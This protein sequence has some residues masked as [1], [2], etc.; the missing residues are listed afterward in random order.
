MKLRSL[1]LISVCGIL[2]FPLLNCATK[3]DAEEKYFLITTNLKIP[4]WQNAGAGF[5]QAGQVLGVPTVFSGPDTYDPQAQRQAF[6]QAIQSKAT[7]ILVSVADPSIMKEEIDRAIEQ[8]VPVLTLD[9]DAP[10][11]K[12][13]FFVGTNNYQGGF[14]G[15]KRLA[16]DLKNKGNVAIFS[17]VAQANLEER[18]RGY[19]DALVSSPGIKIVQIV[20]IHGDPLSR[21]RYNHADP[22]QR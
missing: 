3:H 16:L 17:I 10:A 1:L 12:R 22:W 18:L 2:L 15:G 8:G 11:S 7:G 13:L 9:S 21:F 5:S 19:R 14:T 20:D 4:Y 6:Q